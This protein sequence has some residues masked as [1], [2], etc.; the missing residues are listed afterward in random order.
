MKRRDYI[1]LLLLSWVI[2]LGGCSGCNINKKKSSNNV[3]R[4]LSTAE[5]RLIDSIN[6]KNLKTTLEKYITSHPSDIG[7]PPSLGGWL[8]IQALSEG[9]EDKIIAIMK[10]LL[11]YGS[12]IN[13]D[14][15]AFTP[16]NAA[17]K[18]KQEQV[19]KFM[20]NQPNIDI[21]KTVSQ[22]PLAPIHTAVIY[23]S[24]DIVQTLLSKGACV[25]TRTTDEFRPLIKKE[26]TALHILVSCPF[27][28]TIKGINLNSPEESEKILNLLLD[29]PDVDVNAKDDEDKTPLYLCKEALLNS[30][31]LEEASTKR[32][33]E[34]VQNV[35]KAKSRV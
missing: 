28:Y 24:A 2:L 15:G 27:R 13:E 18:N 17:L 1:L 8:W 16:L 4:P 34:H 30:R 35:L 32:F 25:N 7:R 26:S 20:L 29:H 5:K 31:T 23:N 6:N 11:A 9:N 22:W 33:L 21:N 12:D 14:D 3:F 10:L 19:A